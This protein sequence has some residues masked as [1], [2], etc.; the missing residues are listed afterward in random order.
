[1]N[2]IY[3]LTFWA[4]AIERATSAAAT[5]ALAVWTISGTDLI[6]APWYATA[7]AAAIAAI[8]DILRSLASANRGN[9]GTAGTTPAIQASANPG[10][11][12]QLLGGDRTGT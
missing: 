11:L 9:P 10:H 7:S 6:S 5:A 8:A 4:D 12:M 1:M 2:T 3:R